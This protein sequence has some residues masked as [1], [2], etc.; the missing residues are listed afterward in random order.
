MTTDNTTDGGKPRRYE[1]RR[2]PVDAWGRPVAHHC[3]D[4]GCWV[5]DIETHDQRCGDPNLGLSS[6]QLHALAAS[7][8]GWSPAPLGSQDPGEYVRNFAMH[9]LAN[10]LDKLAGPVLRK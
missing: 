4:C 8:R 7:C 6:A 2:L 9:S 10:A 3:A 1:L 5:A